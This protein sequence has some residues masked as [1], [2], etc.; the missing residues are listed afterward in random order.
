MSQRDHVGGK[1]M[2][3]IPKSR[4]RKVNGYVRAALA[5][6]AVRRKR[7]ARYDRFV[8]PLDRKRD[9][10]AAEVATRL[11]TLSGGQHAAAQRL[12][13]AITNTGAADRGVHR[14]SSGAE[15]LTS[16]SSAG[17]R[18]DVRGYSASIPSKLP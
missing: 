7:D 18:D 1:M 11:Q 14:A 6:D 8:R 17:R 10:L 16:W 5:L 9:Q 3:A 13:A 12:L 15:S 4:S 2:E